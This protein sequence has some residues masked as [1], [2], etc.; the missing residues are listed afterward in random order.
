MYSDPNYHKNEL[1]RECICEFNHT[2]ECTL[3]TEDY[4]PRKIRDKILL[5]I[6]KEFIRAWKRLG[7]ADRKYQR[8]IKYEV[9]NRIGGRDPVEQPPS[10]EQSNKSLVAICEDVLPKAVPKND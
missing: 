9:M 10:E 3:D 1:M 8:R 5:L 4:V 6:C 7:K 2:F